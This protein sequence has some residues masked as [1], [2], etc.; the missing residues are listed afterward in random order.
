M[1]TPDDDGTRSSLVNGLL[2]AANHAAW[3][4]FCATYGPRL[5]TAC[6]RFGVR[7]PAD[8]DDV[9]ANVL[10]CVARAMRA[11]WVYNPSLTFRG[12]LTTLCRNEAN[13]HLKKMN[14]RAARGG[15]GSGDS[16]VQAALREVPAPE[17]EQVEADWAET[18]RQAAECVKAKVDPVHWECFVLHG[19]EKLPGADVA[20]R[21]GLSLAAVYQIK[22][23]VAAKL[24][25]EFQQLF[26][27]GAASGGGK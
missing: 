13:R 9:V 15:I 2:D 22:H 8:L 23:R 5:R 3:E 11:G 21:L 25:S 10:V 18:M 14:G 20:A 26:G 6:Q 19:V 24:R 7:Q 27:G 17:I 1:S 12:W 4:R 16:G